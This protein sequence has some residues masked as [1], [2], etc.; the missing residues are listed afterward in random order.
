MN[1]LNKNIFIVLFLFVILA[2]DAS[3]AIRVF[4]QVN[5]SED[6]YVGEN[7][8]YH[9]IIDGENKAGQVDLTSLARHNPRSAGNRDISQTSIS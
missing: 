2:G 5:T 8:G 6:I 7:F 4:A 1:S 9:I 3:A